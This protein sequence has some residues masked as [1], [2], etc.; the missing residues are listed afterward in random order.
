MALVHHELRD[1]LVA[2]I[3]AGRELSPDHD[4]AL[5]DVFLRAA[6][7]RLGA[8]APQPAPSL[9][10]R[11]GPAITA[12]SLALA[13]LL[14]AFMLFHGG[15][16]S[17]AT[18]RSVVVPGMVDHDQDFHAPDWWRGDGRAPNFQSP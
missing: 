11:F 18:D 12:A 5:A 3:A 1:D 14:L 4:Y 9:W 17:G 15:P 6:R 8:Q 16:A 7:Q 2:V 10:S 13:A